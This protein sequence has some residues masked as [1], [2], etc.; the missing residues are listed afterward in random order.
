MPVNVMIPASLVNGF[1][2]GE[3]KEVCARPETGRVEL[4]E[5]GGTDRKSDIWPICRGAPVN[6]FVCTGWKGGAELTTGL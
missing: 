4:A 3:A 2:A 1:R 6:I 5:T